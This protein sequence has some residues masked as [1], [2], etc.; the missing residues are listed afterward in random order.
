[1]GLIVGVVVGEPVKN[2]A[3]LGEIYIALLKFIGAP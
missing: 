3:I 2:T 1:V